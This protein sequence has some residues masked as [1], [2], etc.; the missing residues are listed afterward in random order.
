MNITLWRVSLCLSATVLAAV[1]VANVCAGAPPSQSAPFAMRVEAEET[2][3][4]LPP[5]EL[6]NNG[7]GMFWGFGSAQLVRVDGKLFVS[8][9]EHVP[10]AAPLNNARWALYE[11]GEQG[12][13]LCQRDLKDRTREPCP[14]CVSH[15]G[16]L[17]MSVN[18]TLTPLIPAGAEKRSAG[19]PARPEFLEFDAAYPEKEPKHLLPPWTGDPKFTEHSYRTFAADGAR[20]DFILFQNI[21]STHSQWAF[22]DQVGRWTTGQLVWPK[23]EDPKYA[24]YHD[25]RA[26]VNYPNAI[27][28]QRTVHFLGHS[29]LNIWNRIDPLKPETYGREKWGARMRKLHYAWTPDIT[30]QPFSEWTVIDDTMNDGGVLWLGDS[31]LAPDGR[32]HVVWRKEPIHPKLRDTYFPDIKRDWQLCYGIL[33]DGKVLEKRVLLSG[34]ETGGPLRPSGQARFHITP[35]NT[36]YLFYFVAGATP[37]TQKQTGNYAMR[38]GADGAWSAP[39]RIPWQRPVTST[40]FTATPRSGNALTEAADLLIADTLDNK[41][42]VRYARLRFIP[43]CA[44]AANDA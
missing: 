31:W 22:L 25:L 18:P 27:L 12:W 17:L 34:G 23:G 5:Y 7:S 1:L 28:N 44:P 33:K 9:F 30:A 40:F 10:D 35:D 32:V 8:A 24:P 36:L 6:T 19:G 20:G 14:L 21:G 13:R 16:R 37:D 39:V 11:R 42:I 2:V 26:R 3:C 43:S 38:L 41:P 29:P 4:Q 15:A